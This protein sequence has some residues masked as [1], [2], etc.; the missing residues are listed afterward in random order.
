MAEPAR[1]AGGGGA[2]GEGLGRSRGGFTSKLHLSADGRCRPL[3]LVVTGG[4]RADCTQF[5][6]VSEKIRVPRVGPGRPRTKP[7]SLAA[8]KGYSSGPCR[9]YLR[10]RGI[11]HSLPEKTDSQAARLRK[12]S[13]GGR[14]PGFDEERYKKRNTVERAINRLKQSRAV[15]TR[16]DKRG[17]VFLGTATTAALLIW[18]R[19]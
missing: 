12:G 4:Q 16:Y 1:P 3:S 9:K 18:L 11:R 7:D 17:Y 19:S 14:P 5:Q 10:R 2:G 6:T 15:A 13:R 8:D